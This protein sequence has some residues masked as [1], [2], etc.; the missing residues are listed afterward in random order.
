MGGGKGGGRLIL[1]KMMGGGRSK[2]E[3]CREKKVWK[4]RGEQMVMGKGVDRLML[5][6]IGGWGE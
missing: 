1:M 4:W 5:K 2:D 3:Q 6:E